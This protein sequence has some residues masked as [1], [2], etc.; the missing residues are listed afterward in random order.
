MSIDKICICQVC[1]DLL[2]NPVIPQCSHNLCY[3]CANKIISTSI[4][5]QDPVILT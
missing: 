3:D 1:L 2:K 5:A 4:I